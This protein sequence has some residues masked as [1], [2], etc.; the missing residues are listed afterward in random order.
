MLAR[1]AL[2]APLQIKLAVAQSVTEVKVTADSGADITSSDANGDTSVMTAADLKA[3]PVF[4]NDY[5]T[6]MSGFLD[7]GDTATAGAGLMVD[8]VES[9]RVTVSA[10]AVQEIHINEDPYTARYYRPGRGQMEIITKPTA[11]EYHGEFNFL[12]RDSAL[13]AQNAFAPSKP[14]EQRQDLRRQCDRAG[15]GTARRRGFCS[16]LIAPRKT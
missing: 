8:G 12:F 4:D 9:N 14:Y 15:W 13:N 6:A 10:S 7:S 5:V 3:L 16:R 1:T 11:D 2:P